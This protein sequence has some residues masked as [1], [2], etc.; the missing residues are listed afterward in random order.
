MAK[1]VSIQELTGFLLDK[2]RHPNSDWR[3]L[4]GPSSHVQLFRDIKRT[5]NKLQTEQNSAKRVELLDTLK[6]QVM[7]LQAVE[8]YS[9][10]EMNDIVESI[11][12]IKEG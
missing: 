8:Y 9:E 11:E 5:L 1:E 2:F 4:G 12:S 6:G 10:A 7:L 3:Y